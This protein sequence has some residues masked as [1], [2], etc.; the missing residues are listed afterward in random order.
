M[1]DYDDDDVR[2]DESDE[3][4]GIERRWYDVPLTFDDPDQGVE[5]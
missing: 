1:N 3:L 4:H 2:R 5:S